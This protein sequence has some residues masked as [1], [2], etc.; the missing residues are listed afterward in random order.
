MYVYLL[1][2]WSSLGHYVRLVVEI[3]WWSRKGP[4]AGRE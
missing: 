2:P 3:L 1:Y 4:Y